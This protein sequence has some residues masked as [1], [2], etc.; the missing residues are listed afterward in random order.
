MCGTQVPEAALQL[1]SPSD[2]TAA[3]PLALSPP[4][5]PP[6][7][8]VPISDAGRMKTRQFESSSSSYGAW[9]RGLA[10]LFSGQTWN[11][12]SSLMQQG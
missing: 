10:A 1:A 2:R 11:A 8:P 9:A 6:L 7:C 3:S 4:P 12:P 5:P